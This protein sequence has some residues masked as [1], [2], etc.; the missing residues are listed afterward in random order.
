MENQRDGSEE[1]KPSIENNVY[2][3]FN[4]KNVEM[5]LFIKVL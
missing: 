5:F 2:R 1:R 3:I 4:K